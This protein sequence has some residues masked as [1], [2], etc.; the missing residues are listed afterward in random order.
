MGGGG[1]LALGGNKNSLKISI[2]PPAGK[3][4][5]RPCITNSI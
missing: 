4:H 3:Y 5:N 2:I 1:G